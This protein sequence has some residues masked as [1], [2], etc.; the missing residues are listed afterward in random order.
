LI[1]KFVNQLGI[2]THTFQAPKI[3]QRRWWMEIFQGQLPIYNFPQEDQETF[4]MSIWDF[5][6]GYK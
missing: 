3:S 2:L 1:K 4:I 6:G 5:N